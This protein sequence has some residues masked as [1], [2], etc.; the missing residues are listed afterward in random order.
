MTNS[1]S[2][3][4]LLQNVFLELANGNGRPFL[5][6][7][8]EDMTWT[9]LG[10]TTWSRSYRG[11]RAVVEDLMRP[12]FAQFADRYTNTAQRFI[13]EDDY[14]VVECNGQVTTKAG[15]PYNNRY[16]YICH[17]E[18]GKLRELTEYLDTELVATALAS[19]PGARSAK[20]ES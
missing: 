16:C 18:A 10:T 5:D 14:V 12:L 7:M 3:K 8:A 17:F 13:A 6:L 19:Y 2:N 15:Q 4:A 20:T 11:K 9:V 1:A